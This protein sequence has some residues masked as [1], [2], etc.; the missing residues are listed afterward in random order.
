MALEISMLTQRV[1]WALIAMSSDLHSAILKNRD[2][3]AFTEEF[4][5]GKKEDQEES[6]QGS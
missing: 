4:H 5:N 2:S 6:R 3:P 1:R